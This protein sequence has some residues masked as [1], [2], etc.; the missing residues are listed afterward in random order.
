M[1]GA[2]ADLGV[3]SPSEVTFADTPDERFSA[4]FFGRYAANVES[5]RR[6]GDAMPGTSA[7]ALEEVQLALPEP[8]RRVTKVSISLALRWTQS[9][10]CRCCT[11]L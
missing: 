1:R 10:D 5:L 9:G 3:L 11:F 8:R 6:M 7:N 2:F 4:A